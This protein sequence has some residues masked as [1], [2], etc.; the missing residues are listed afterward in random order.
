MQII[1]KSINS[2][3]VNV[4]VT[5]K[6]TIGDL[7]PILSEELNLQIDRIKLVHAGRCIENEQD[8]TLESWNI[9]DNSIIHLAK[10]QSSFIIDIPF[11]EYNTMVELVNSQ[12]KEIEILKQLLDAARINLLWKSCSYE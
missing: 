7:L 10:K 3:I 12:K 2:Q 4:D 1:I 8:Q 9:K 6:T 11:D 5:H